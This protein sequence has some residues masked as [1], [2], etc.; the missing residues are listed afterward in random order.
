MEA[1]SDSRNENCLWCNIFLERWHWCAHWARRKTSLN[2][3]EDDMSEILRTILWRWVKAK[4]KFL[5]SCCNTAGVNDAGYCRQQYNWKA[6]G[7]S[8]TT[9]CQ[10]AIS[11]NYTIFKTRLNKQWKPFDPK[12]A[13]KAQ[14]IND[15]ERENT[16][17]N[18]RS[19]ICKSGKLQLPTEGV[20]QLQRPRMQFGV[21]SRRTRPEKT[22]TF[23]DG[24]N[25]MVI[26]EE[27]V[28]SQ[29]TIQSF[30]Q[31]CLE[32]CHKTYVIFSG[33]ILEY[34]MRIWSVAKA[35]KSYSAE[36]HDMQ[37]TIKGQVSDEK[38]VI[39]SY[40]WWTDVWLLSMNS[41]RN[42]CRRAD[43]CRNVKSLQF[44][45]LFNGCSNMKSFHLY[46][47][48]TSVSNVKNLHLYLYT[49]MSF[50]SLISV[51]I[52]VDFIHS[53]YFPRSLRL[54][55]WC[56]PLWQPWRRN[57]PSFRSGCENCWRASRISYS[58]DLL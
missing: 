58:H 44:L 31:R 22:F 52:I 18:F 11:G 56:S 32:F 57:K 2:I 48:W 54:Y 47:Y 10:E 51:C 29:Q 19:F 24:M 3:F 9:W 20:D 25:H 28:S 17:C 16:A 43:R 8:P 13:C 46:P 1:D 36:Q 53:V 7:S 42:G 50:T 41:Q 34:W 38:H 49:V 33:I 45:P 4:L 26:F 55:P 39:Q 30:W 37:Q 21:E 27:N 14:H 12:R 5:S 15:W 40:R 23:E 6:F 35:R